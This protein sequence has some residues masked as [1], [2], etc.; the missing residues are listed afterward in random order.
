MTPLP[1][2]VVKR[3]PPLHTQDNLPDTQLTAYAR[4]TLKMLD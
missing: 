1:D 3:I 4:L 2:D